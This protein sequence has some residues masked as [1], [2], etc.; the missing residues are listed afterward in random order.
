MVVSSI[1]YEGD[2]FQKFLSWTDEKEVLGK[3][4]LKLAKPS[5]RSLLEV[6]AGN[7]DLTEHYINSFEK[8]ILL[9]PSQQ[10]YEHL[11]KRFPNA[12][13]IK[14]KAEVSRS[15]G[16]LF[17]LIVA[18]HVFIY[19][20][21]PLDTISKLCA[22]LHEGGRFVI[23]MLD[24]NCSYLRFVDSFSNE[25]I[26][27]K[28]DRGEVQWGDVVA[29]AEAQRMLFQVIDVSS[30]IIAPSINDF[31][32]MNDFHFNTDVSSLTEPVL[33]KMQQYLKEHIS[34]NCLRIDV[35]HKMIVV[36]G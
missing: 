4:I 11:L 36:E 27:N 23:I 1:A 19:V 8:A 3:E 33:S 34:D 17:D 15:S 31:L 35:G 32:S 20:T 6:G 2:S 13:V 25:V 9:E 14:T 28:V 22:L 18:S 21:H 10:Y 16:G 24:R 12:T 7:G 26:G 29:Y 30:S 5:Y